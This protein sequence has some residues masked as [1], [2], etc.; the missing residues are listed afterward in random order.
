MILSHS[1]VECENMPMS[2]IICLVCLKVVTGGI[3]LSL[4]VFCLHLLFLC[5]FVYVWY[6][7]LHSGLVVSLEYCHGG[8]RKLYLW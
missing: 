8:H 4:G 7:G 2:I 3:M 6:V 5:L 1:V